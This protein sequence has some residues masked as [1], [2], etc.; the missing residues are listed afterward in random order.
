MVVRFNKISKCNREPP[1]TYP[2]KMQ[3]PILISKSWQQVRVAQP[4]PDLGVQIQRY[5]PVQREPNGVRGPVR[6]GQTTCLK[7]A[8]LCLVR[9]GLHLLHCWQAAAWYCC[10]CCN[11]HYCCDCW[12]VMQ[13][14]EEFP[15]E[16]WYPLNAH[17]ES[18]SICQECSQQKREQCCRIFQ[19]RLVPETLHMKNKY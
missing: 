19:T 11:Y 10:C 4:F 3:I 7:A 5:C 2:L 8:Q 15:G 18:S 6:T 9:E 1:T 14:T 13:M 16:S 12:S 17:H